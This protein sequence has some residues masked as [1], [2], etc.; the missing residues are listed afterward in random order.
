MRSKLPVRG[1]DPDRTVKPQAIGQASSILATMEKKLVDG[2]VFAAPFPEIIEARGLGR[3]V[4]N[5]L[6]GE[7]PEQRDVP[8]AIMA[9]SRDTWA[10]KPD[11]IRGA[12]R[13]LTKAFKFT[14]EKPAETRNVMRK[15]FPEIE[16]PIFDRIVAT[17]SKA[18]PTTPV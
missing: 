13:A 7:I 2:F 17:Y 16:E 10:K 6:A 15:Y 12:T 18:V 4:I 1:V 8:Y 5:P 9:T 11:V 14:H 3:I